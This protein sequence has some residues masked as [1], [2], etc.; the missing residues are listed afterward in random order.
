MCGVSIHGEGSKKLSFL[1]P[2]KK[3][4]MFAGGRCPHYVLFTTYDSFDGWREF[5]NCCRQF[6][7]RRHSFCTERYVNL[8]RRTALE[9]TMHAFDGG[10]RHRS[11]T[12]KRTCFIDSGLTGFISLSKQH[13]LLTLPLGG[14]P[15]LAANDCATRCSAF[16]SRRAR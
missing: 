2:V 3:P 13:C 9:Q 11:R 5:G 12:I 16:R 1:I 10:R 15:N 4:K 14:Y 8:L 7:N 6:K